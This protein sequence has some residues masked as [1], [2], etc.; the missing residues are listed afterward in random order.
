[1]N[2]EHIMTRDPVACDIDDTAQD[3]ARLLKDKNIGAAV[4]LRNGQVAGIVTDRQ[5]ALEVCAEGRAA[6]EVPIRGV[7]TARPA[8]LTLDDNL[9]SAIDALRSAGFVRRLPVVNTENQLVG[10]VSL[11]DIA[12]IAKDLLDAVLL[13][14]THH[15]LKEARVPTGGKRL[16]KQIRRPTKMDELARGEKARPVLRSAVGTRG[17]AGRGRFGAFGRRAGRRAPKRAV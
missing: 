13:D 1:M 17:K 3:V 2:I 4:V 5:L 12:V 9:F 14:E 8:I 15:A 10:L 16:L 11:S 7:M 6:S